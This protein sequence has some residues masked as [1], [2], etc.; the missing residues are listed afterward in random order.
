MIGDKA[1]DVV[2]AKK[3]GI[4]SIGVS[5]GYGSIAELQDAQANAVSNS[6]TELQQILI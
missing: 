5:Y 6:V 4:D 2:G 1:Q 3:V